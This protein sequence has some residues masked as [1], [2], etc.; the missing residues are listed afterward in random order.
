VQKDRIRPSEQ[1]S[2]RRPGGD[3]GLADEHRRLQ[4][5]DRQHV[6]PGDVIGYEERRTWMDLPLQVEAHAEHGEQHARPRLRDGK[7]RRSRQ[8]RKE[9]CSDEAAEQNENYSQ[10]LYCSHKWREDS[11]GVMT[12]S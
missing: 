6:Q 10:Y 12:E 2:Q 8:Q 4:G 1:P 3:L 5:A 9:R 7:P 11:R